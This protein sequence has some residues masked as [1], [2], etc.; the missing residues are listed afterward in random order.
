MNL[1]ASN[2]LDATDIPAKMATDDAEVTG[3]ETRLYHIHLPML[4]DARIIEWD[5][6]TD[7]VTR[8]PA[9][10]EIQPLLTLM[11]EHR[12]ELPEHWF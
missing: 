4:D 7:V 11:D 2:P 5:R 12:D 1:L 6:D 10:H 8:G 3:F 9:F